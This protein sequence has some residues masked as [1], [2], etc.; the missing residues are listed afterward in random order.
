MGGGSDH[1]FLRG[2][3][4]N[5]P[6]VLQLISNSDHHETEMMTGDSIYEYILREFRRIKSEI[7][8]FNLDKKGIL[9]LILISLY[10][11]LRLSKFTILLP[12]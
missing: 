2:F 12:P 3:R 6:K 10:F 8:S 7:I 9:F 4:Y 1:I 5:N 11:R